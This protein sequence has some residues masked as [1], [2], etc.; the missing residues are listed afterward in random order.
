[1]CSPPP[2]GGSSPSGP[3]CD[4]NPRRS[5]PSGWRTVH[6]FLT[7]SAGRR[8]VLHDALKHIIR[9][10]DWVRLTFYFTSHH[11]CTCAPFSSSPVLFS[12]FLVL[13]CTGCARAS[14]PHCLTSSLLPITGTAGTPHHSQPGLAPPDDPTQR[15]RQ[16]QR[17]ADS[18]GCGRCRSTPTSSP[19]SRPRARRSAWTVRAAA[20]PRRRRPPRRLPRRPPRRAARRAAARRR[21]STSHHSMGGGDH[22]SEMGCA[23]GAACVTHKGI[24]LR[25]VFP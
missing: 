11:V 20:R 6:N 17:Q 13:V 21:P 3:P 16:T 5:G 10:V 23:I 7:E 8:A 1:M 18:S 2:G 19:R 14:P 12:C 4:R 22:G 24:L 9:I 15:Q 25:T